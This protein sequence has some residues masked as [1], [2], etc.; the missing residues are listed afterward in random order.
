MDQSLITS[1]IPFIAIL[2]IMYFLVFR[3]QQQRMK[4]LREAVD[5]VRRGDT[6]VTAGGIIGRVV[7][8]KDEGEV[9]VEIADNVQVRILKATISEVR[10]KAAPA[11]AKADN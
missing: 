6:V 4:Q 7:K 8:V 10:A 1:M 2:G 5:N 3:P 11:D 9:L